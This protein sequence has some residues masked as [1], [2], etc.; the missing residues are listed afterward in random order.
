M[1]SSGIEPEHQRLSAS[2]KT[3]HKARPTPALN[4]GHPAGREAGGE[5]AADAGR[6]LDLELRLVAV[7]RVLD[8]GE[9]EAGAAGVARAATVDAVEA[10]GEA[11]DMLGVDYTLS[12]HDAL[13]I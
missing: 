11:G 3:D 8:D 1:V 6:A 2:P 12:L 7:Q 4:P 9:A 13:P 10:F 5:A